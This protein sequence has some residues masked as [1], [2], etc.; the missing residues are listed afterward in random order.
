MI[1]SEQLSYALHE[2]DVRS[3]EQGQ[4]DAARGALAGDLRYPSE[5]GDWQLGDFDLSEYLDR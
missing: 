5:T 4:R 3:D 2:C 1:D